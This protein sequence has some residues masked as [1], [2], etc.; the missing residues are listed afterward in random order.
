MKAEQLGLGLTAQEI[1]TVRKS[2]GREPNE[3]EWSPG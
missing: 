1:A 3:T 2:L